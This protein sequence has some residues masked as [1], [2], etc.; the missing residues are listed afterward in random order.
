MYKENKGLFFI[1]AY[2]IIGVW[3]DIGTAGYEEPF[4]WSGQGWEPRYLI[5]ILPFITLVSG[6]LLLHLKNLRFKNKPRLLMKVSIL[7]N[8]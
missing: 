6:T 7:I 1:S 8:R 4:G 3:L 2:V 5:S